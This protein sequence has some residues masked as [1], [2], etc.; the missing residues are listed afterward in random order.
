MT[1]G[2][3]VEQP[4]EEK[5]DAMFQLLFGVNIDRGR[6]ESLVSDE[7]DDRPL[8]DVQ[9]ADRLMQRHG[10][11][12][13]PASEVFVTLGKLLVLVWLGPGLQALQN[14]TRPIPQLG[15]W[16]FRHA[17]EFAFPPDLLHRGSGDLLPVIF[18]QL[19]QSIGK[20]GPD[21]SFL[22]AILAHPALPPVA[23]RGARNWTGAPMGGL[24]TVRRTLEFGIA[25]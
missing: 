12:D 14:V 3:V 7:V 9:S 4:V 6:S 15:I 23:H 24:L 17:Q 1:S 8:Q 19:N 25:I 5:A 22:G 2:Y 13:T 16:Q 18:S 21:R 10:L 11:L 20:H